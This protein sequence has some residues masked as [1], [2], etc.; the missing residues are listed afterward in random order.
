MNI[1][2]TTL[3]FKNERIHSGN[4]TVKELKIWPG[5]K[6]HSGVI[7]TYQWKSQPNV[8]RKIE[9]G[10]DK[11]V[12]FKVI[13]EAFN[14]E[15]NKSSAGA[16]IA[17]LSYE[18]GRVNLYLKPDTQLANVR[19]ADEIARELKIKPDKPNTGEPVEI[20]KV[21]FH[22]VDNIFMTCDQAKSNTFIDSR[23]AETI[24]GARHS[25]LR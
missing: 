5:W 22:N 25:M 7:A 17:R 19:I 4:I 13:S 9:I 14:S 16:T 1:I 21:A 24:L 2:L 23:E 12:T 10:N 3:E 8:V 11:V 18:N 20:D 6:E 15:L